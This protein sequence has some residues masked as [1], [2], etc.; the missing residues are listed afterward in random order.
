MSATSSDRDG[1]KLNQT[2]TITKTCNKEI[3]SA[4]KIEIFNGKCLIVFLFL[5][6]TEIVGIL[7]N[8]LGD[9]VLT[10]THNLC[11]EAKIRNIHVG[12]PCK[13]H[14]YYTKVGYKEYTF[15]GHVFLMQILHHDGK[16]Q[17]VHV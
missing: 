13:P 3:F 12:I 4:V 14:F 7:L 9:A 5:L 10:S 1:Q 8:R 11:F 17:G 16:M 2:H 6:K 15:Q